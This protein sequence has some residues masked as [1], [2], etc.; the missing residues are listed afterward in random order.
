MNLIVNADDFGLT[1]S[2]NR[3]ILKGMTDGIVTS[4]TMV[5]G[6]REDAFSHAA[7]LYRKHRIDVGVHLVL[8]MGRPVLTDVRSLVNENGNFYSLN[9]IGAHIDGMDRTELKAEFMAQIDKIRSAGIEVTHLDSHHHVHMLSGVSEVYLEIARE[10]GLPVRAFKD[11]Q[12][13]AADGHY[14]ER[15]ITDF[16]GNG[17]SEASLLGL[18]NTL[19]GESAEIM[20]HPAYVDQELMEMTRYNTARE[21]ELKLLTEAKIKAEVNRLG[22]NLIGY[23]EFTAELG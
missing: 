18:L 17:V 2:I 6:G 14:P 23:R 15:I 19:T 21:L 9:D 22:I 8:T 4:C 13:G 20:C 16:Y 3:G 12:A 7:E 10:Q 5:A 1:K 11:R